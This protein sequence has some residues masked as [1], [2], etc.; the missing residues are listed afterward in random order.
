MRTVSGLAKLPLVTIR[1]WSGS[2]ASASASPSTVMVRMVW[3]VLCSSTRRRA[4]ST[5]ANPLRARQATA[6]IGAVIFRTRGAG[7]GGRRVEG[8]PGPDD[9]LTPKPATDESEHTMG[10]EHQQAEKDAAVTPGSGGERPPITFD[11]RNVW[12]VLLLVLAAV[13]LA[14]FVL[15]L[16]EDAGS[17]FFTLLMAWAASIAMEPAVGYLARHGWRRGLAT[18]LVMVAAVVAALIF[19]ALF[20]QLLVEQLVQLV[21]S[22]P[23]LIDSVL[24]WVNTTFD[25][26]L[27]PVTA[28]EQIGLGG[29]AI[30]G[31]VSNVAGGLFGF[32]TS[33]LSSVFG[34]F[35]FGLFAFYLSADAPRLQRWIARF[36]PRSAREV[37][38]GIY[39]LAVQKAGGYVAARLVLATINGTTTAIFLWAI[40]MNY[41]LALGIWTGVVAQF[42]PTIGTYIAI[43]LPVLVGLISD[44]PIDGV[45]A[46]IWALV[47]Q[48]V[49]NLTLEPKISAKAVDLHPAV[50]FASVMLG[51]SLFGAAGAVL[52]VP[53]AAMGVAL[54]EQYAPKYDVDPEP[55]DPDVPDPSP[56]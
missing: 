38:E 48:Q 13:A 45:L 14:L 41:W 16:L 15:F 52:A 12:K 47:Y 27:D 8:W 11:L 43:A 19:F 40:G 17:V 26:S 44:D 21:Q 1:G 42:V 56:A 23:D 35:T 49:E 28:L 39:E 50:S 9:A 25:T 34:V 2:V 22:L 30:G 37:N 10:D 33:F 32:V 4:V 18:G 36:I 46:L 5:L 51:A 53:V 24:A 20:G 6:G 55:G 31:I 7:R 54:F 3:G 29:D